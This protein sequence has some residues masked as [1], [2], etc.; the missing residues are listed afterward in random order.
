M[1]YDEIHNI[2]FVTCAMIDDNN[3]HDSD[4]VDGCCKAC[5]ELYDELIDDVIDDYQSKHN[6]KCPTLLFIIN[7]PFLPHGHFIGRVT[8]SLIFV[9]NSKTKSICIW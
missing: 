5:I 2:Q 9:P 1:K 7:L 3:I 8:K 4:L 6:F